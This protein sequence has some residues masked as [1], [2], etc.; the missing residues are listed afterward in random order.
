[1]SESWARL[2]PY[3]NGVARIYFR[4]PGGKIGQG[5]GGWE[6]LVSSPSEPR[7]SRVKQ[8]AKRDS[9]RVVRYGSCARGGSVWVPS[10]R[11]GD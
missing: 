10:G 7:L 3:R 5:K 8:M 9:Q 2:H 6:K 11:A 1:M 4:L